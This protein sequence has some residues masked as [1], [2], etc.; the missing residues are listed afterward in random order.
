[1][2]GLFPFFYLVNQTVKNYKRAENQFAQFGSGY[3]YSAISDISDPDRRYLGDAIVPIPSTGT[4]LL[5]T[6][7]QSLETMTRFKGEKSL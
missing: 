4:N 6:A 5:A 1:V 2:F 7:V 3:L